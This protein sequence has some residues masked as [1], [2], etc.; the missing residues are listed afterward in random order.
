MMVTKLS[1]C[2]TTLKRLE[3]VSQPSLGFQKQQSGLIQ[4][5]AEGLLQRKY[6]ELPLSV[7]ESHFLPAPPTS[8]H[9]ISLWD[10]GVD[11]KETF[12]GD[13]VFP[14]DQAITK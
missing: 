10:T 3:L 9:M 1:S 12:T 7:H 5:K 13:C 11:T 8:K 4:P 14:T 2:K 6:L